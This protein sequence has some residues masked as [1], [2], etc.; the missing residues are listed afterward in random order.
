MRWGVDGFRCSPIMRGPTD[1]VS[2]NQ[3]K[4][5]SKQKR[6]VDESVETS[7]N[8]R[9]SGGADTGR[10][11]EKKSQQGVDGNENY[12]IMCG[13]VRRFGDE[14][15]RQR[16]EALRPIPTIFDSVRR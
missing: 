3:K 13:S 9:P 8:V 15:K 1:G 11:E 16:D 2:T 12:P 7:H 6:S 14:R 5:R 10:Q 4:G